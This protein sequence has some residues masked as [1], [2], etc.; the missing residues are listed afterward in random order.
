[1]LPT[2]EVA[3]QQR[4]RITN[5]LDERQNFTIEVLDP[6]GANL[7]VSESPIAVEPDEVVT[8]NA[9][10]T[11]PRSVFVDGQAPVRYLVRSDKGFSKEVEFLLLGPYRSGDE[12]PE[13]ERE[14]DHK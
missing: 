6:K 1:M 11:V 4:V 8:V 3:N 2:G 12:H 7:V 13:K 9:V 14:E 5:Q 10:A